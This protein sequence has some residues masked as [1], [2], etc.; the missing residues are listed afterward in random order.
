MNKKVF[1]FS[2]TLLVILSLAAIPVQAVPKQKLDFELCIEGIS[3]SYGPWGTYHAGPRGTEDANPEP[4]PLIQRTFHAKEVEFIFVS[5]QLNIGTETY[6]LDS[7]SGWNIAGVWEFICAG[8]YT[9]RYV[10]MQY[11][12]FF[13]GFGTYPADGDVIFF[14]QIEGMIDRDT[15]TVM[16]NGAYYLDPEYNE[17]TGY[18]F[19]AALTINPADGSMDGTLS[20]SDG[21]TGLSFVSTSGD[22]VDVDGYF[23]IT[24]EHSFNFNWNTLTGQSK[25]KDTITFY[26]SDGM[27]VWGTLPVSVRDTFLYVFNN[28]GVFVNLISEGNI[29]GK[30]TGALKEA[31]IAG[32]TSGEV[33]HW[34]GYVP[35]M[36]LTRAGTIIGWTS[37][38]S[39]P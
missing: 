34:V 22:A 4:K 39:S 17:T 13:G 5:A 3:A 19:T 9:H 14:E 32:T 20:D 29:F 28:Q 23:G 27:T 15:G 7:G 2:L 33:A 12:D 26:G 1:L 37:P 35:I 24:E 30:G 21:A 25:A 8:S 6:Y 16:F 10:I 18:T 31:K 11:G 36:G 38:P